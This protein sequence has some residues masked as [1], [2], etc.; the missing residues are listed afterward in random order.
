MSNLNIIQFNKGGKGHN[1][2]EYYYS[3][4]SEMNSHEWDYQKI[5][6]QLTKTKL[7]GY[8]ESFTD[9][10]YSPFIEY[11]K[12]LNEEV[13]LDYF[14]K[15]NDLDHTSNVMTLEN[16]FGRTD[17]AFKR[18]NPVEFGYDSIYFA[19][20]D[21]NQY[22][23]V[24]NSA[25]HNVSLSDILK[26][27]LDVPFMNPN[28]SL[29]D[30]KWLS[31]SYNPD[32]IHDIILYDMMKTY[33]VYFNYISY[34]KI[35]VSVED[36]SRL[37]RIL[38]KLGSDSAIFVTQEGGFDDE[39]LELIHK[40]N[41]E[42]GVE[43]Y[44]YNL[45]LEI[46][47]INSISS[48]VSDMIGTKKTMDIELVINDKVYRIIGLHCKEPK[49]ERTYEKFVKEGLLG[50]TQNSLYNLWYNTIDYFY[51]KMYGYTDKITIMVGDLNPADTEK[52]A[53]VKDM[54][55]QNSS[56]KVYPQSNEITSKKTRSGFCAQLKKFWKLSESCKDMI[57]L[58]DTIQVNSCQVFPQVEELLSK[59]WVGDHC[60]LIVNINI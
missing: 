49:K 24:R 30:S 6:G 16:K 17:S 32:R 59:E 9:S 46:Y 4:G 48:S 35:Y 27:C 60:S 45:D 54:L 8:L 21:H 51:Y 37:D 53:L 57:I 33:S 12:N 10:K 3:N 15:T 36:D 23:Y 20:S 56:F 39:R 41:I 29:S 5:L 1:P 11:V 22:Y 47:R 55:E 19:E 40:V 7:C 44:S 34:D 13:I 52:S 38:D 31:K 42:G 18:F 14:F 28:F 25:R 43:L 26:K 58:D 50:F 2:F